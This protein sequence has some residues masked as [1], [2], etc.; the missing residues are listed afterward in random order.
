MTTFHS[1]GGG[2]SLTSADNSFLDHCEGTERPSQY[3][4]TKTRHPEVPEARQHTRHWWSFPC[5]G[6]VLAEGSQKV[7]EK[8][9]Q[10]QHDKNFGT[11]CK[12]QDAKYVSEAH[13]K[14]KPHYTHLTHFTHTKRVAFTL[15]E[16]LITL[17][18]IGVVAAMTIPTLIANYQEKQTVTKLT[19]AYAIMSNAYALAKVEKGPISVQGGSEIDEETGEITFDENMIK[20]ADT[21]LDIIAP[22]L[23]MISRCKGNDQS[24]PKHEKTYTLDGTERLTDYKHFSY[25]TLANGVIIRIGSI[26]IP[27]DTLSCGDFSVDIN[28]FTGPNTNGKDIFYFYINSDGIVPIGKNDDPAR[29]FE[30]YC[31]MDA[32]NEYNGYGCTAWIIYN[33]NMDYL[34]CN[35]LSWDSKHKC[36]E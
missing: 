3:S 32:N 2:S 15:A 33:K 12:V 28:G 27:C 35:D 19:D 16:V 14:H 29:P 13:R 10:V 21:F 9:K 17:A 20:N 7:N 26:K 11:L 22:Y 31:N 1:G 24:C 23:K 6:D 25:S 5:H 36:S 4:Q 30:D 34:H 18:I 8:L